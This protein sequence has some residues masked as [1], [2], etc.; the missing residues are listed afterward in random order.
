MYF[1]FVCLYVCQEHQ[2]RKTAKVILAVLAS[3]YVIKAVRDLQTN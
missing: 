3:S 2:Q 1:I